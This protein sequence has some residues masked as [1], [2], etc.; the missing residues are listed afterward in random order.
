M[1]YCV[2]RKTKS[3]MCTGIILQ[4]MYGAVW[5][6]RK[7]LWC[8][9]W[10]FVMFN[11]FWSFGL[12]GGLLGLNVNVRKHTTRQLIV[13]YKKK[14]NSYANARLVVTTGLLCLQLFWLQM[15]SYYTEKTVYRIACLHLRNNTRSKNILSCRSLLLQTLYLILF[16]LKFTLLIKVLYDHTL[17]FLLS[18]FI[19]PTTT[20]ILYSG[21]FCSDS[22]SHHFV[23][24]FFFHTVTLS[25][26]T[27]H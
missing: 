23:T 25:G 5:D 11:V 27:W 9:S 8:I 3:V 16:L 4:G 24:L 12:K 21:R 2:Q 19:L 1:D 7:A 14:Q 13:L 17:K 10:F 18:S 22:L 20:D 6:L 15:V 26:V